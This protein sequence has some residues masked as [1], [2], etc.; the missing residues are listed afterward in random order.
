M[1]VNGRC[2]GSVKRQQLMLAPES[3]ITR[4]AGDVLYSS[5]KHRAVLHALQRLRG[6]VYLRDHAIRRDQ[7]TFDGR[8][9]CAADHRSWHLVTLDEYGSVIACARFQ[10][11]SPAAR[12]ENLGVSRS[13]IARC[14]VWGTRLRTAVE[15][16]LNRARMTG[17]D[18][19][20]AGG[21]ALDESVRH[22]TEAFR[23]ALGAF[24]WTGLTGG[25]I[26]ITTATFRNH[27]ADILQRLG[28]RPLQSASKE[29]PVYFDPQ[30]DCTMQILRFHS[31]EYAPR[32][33]KSVT[34][35]ARE[36]SRTTVI[37]TAPTPFRSF[38]PSFSLPQNRPAADVRMSA[39]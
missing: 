35:L 8:H 25:A 29:L 11:H 21:W 38:F 20:E 37:S 1:N 23:I 2:A 4:A 22:T 3:D 12:F 10:V 7:L 17:C 34:E 27:S 33:H 13:S 5:N 32:F 39:V 19:I 16:E 36:L 26:G 30:Y 9:E 18:F 14:P 6:R 28:G 31:G 15:S 24:A